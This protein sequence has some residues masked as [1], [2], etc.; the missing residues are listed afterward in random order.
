VRSRA[1]SSRW[2]RQVNR[3]FLS[4]FAFRLTRSNAWT[5]RLT[6]S[7][8]G[9]RFAGRDCSWLGSFGLL[10]CGGGCRFSRRVLPQ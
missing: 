10:Q 3:A 9:M 2:N 6:G 5:H 1:T 8:S 4:N 7:G